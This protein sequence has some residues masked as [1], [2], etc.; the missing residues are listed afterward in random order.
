MSR[1]RKL[2][3]LG[4]RASDTAEFLF[5]DVRVPKKCVFVLEGDFCMCVCDLAEN[6]AAWL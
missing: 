1:L 4:M 3:K 6:V 2:D 5:E